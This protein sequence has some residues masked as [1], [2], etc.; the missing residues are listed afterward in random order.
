MQQSSHIIPNKTKSKDR[1][2][3]EIHR[4]SDG[5]I[6]VKSAIPKKR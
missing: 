3:E 2:N 5:S 6:V 4:N 1:N